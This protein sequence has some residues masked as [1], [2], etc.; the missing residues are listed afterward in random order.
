MA[1]S[2]RPVGP[3]QNHGS[4]NRSISESACNATLKFYILQLELF[5][6]VSVTSQP[7]PECHGGR[8]RDVLTS[9]LSWPVVMVMAQANLNMTVK[10][11]TPDEYDAAATRRA[12]AS[13]R[14]A[15]RTRF[16][17]PLRHRRRRGAA[18]PPRTLWPHAGQYARRT[19]RLRGRSRYAR[20]MARLSARAVQEDDGRLTCTTEV[21]GRP[22][23]QSR[24]ALVTERNGCRR[25]AERL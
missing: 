2:R 17:P 5:S 4:R 21:W 6:F 15:P 25:G 16:L 23:S 10:V 24:G 20:R 18:A 22:P 3:L 8:R 19:A 7:E 1:R 14:H 13:C 11:M 9:G 12:P